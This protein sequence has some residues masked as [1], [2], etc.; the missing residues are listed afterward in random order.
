MPLGHDREGQTGEDSLAVHMHR[1]GAA[2][3][4]PAAFFRAGKAGVIAYGV[5]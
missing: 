3:T 2:L 1:T 5:E 4:M